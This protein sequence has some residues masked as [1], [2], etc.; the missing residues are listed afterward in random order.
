[1][2]ARDERL[3]AEEAADIALGS[4][5]VA[6]KAARKALD[7]LPTLDPRDNVDFQRLAGQERS[8]LARLSPR[9]NRWPGLLEIDERLDRLDLEQQELI[10]RLAELHDRRQGA[11]ERYHQ[12]L[13]RWMADGQDGE[14]PEP[15]AAALDAEIVDMSA[16]HAALD[17]LRAL[18]LE[19][20]VAYVEKRRGSL[21]RDAEKDVERALEE[22]LAAVDAVHGLRDTLLAASSTARW[23]RM[24]P[25]PTAAAPVG[26]EVN[27][28]LGL[29][30]PVIETLGI[31]RQLTA[32]AVLDA[33]KADA[34]T[35]ATRLTPEQ[36]QELGVATASPEQEAMW[37]DDERYQ[38]W[39]RE[40][41][42]KLNE[43]ARGA[44][45]ID[46][47]ELAQQMRDE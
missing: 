21:V 26:V 38:A 31:N 5:A 9:R 6:Q 15:E 34:N 3:A 36:R 10:A 46:V 4:A 22:Y 33:L 30:K 28:A 45:P 32:A 8:V 44:L 16:R 13:A 39:A 43:I 17:E 41:R 14:R 37:Q 40:Q 12:A 24:Y 7:A 18:E 35:I 11:D 23:A 20:K 19:R 29:M 42:E 2:T 47:P 27:L 25:S 1:M